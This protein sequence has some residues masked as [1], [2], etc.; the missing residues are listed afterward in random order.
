MSR[1]KNET[2]DYK[3]ESTASFGPN[4]RTRRRINNQ[5]ADYNPADSPNKSPVKVAVRAEVNDKYDYNIDESINEDR[6][7]INKNSYVFNPPINEKN[8]AIASIN[9]QDGINSRVK[10]S[11]IFDDE[12]GTISP[13]NSR[14]EYTRDK[15]TSDLVEFQTP[16]I[17]GLSPIGHSSTIQRNRKWKVNPDL[18]AQD[19][20]SSDDA[21]VID[22]DLV[23]GRNKDISPHNRHARPRSSCIK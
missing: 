20:D 6:P 23:R 14:N 1:R 4:K 11:K 9:F 8:G 15:R 12:L 7:T 3:D 18:D 17:A 5:T 13:I 16:N 21:H 22:S 19:S 2:Y 10:S